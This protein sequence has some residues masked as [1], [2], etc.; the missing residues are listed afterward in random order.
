MFIAIDKGNSNVNPPINA[1]N[2][3][4]FAYD[5]ILDKLT[6]KD[7]MF[8]HIKELASYDFES[9]LNVN[10][11]GHIFEQSLSDLE[12]LKGEIE[13]VSQ[14]KQKSKRKKDGIFYTPEYI[15][16]YIVEQTVGKYLDENPQMLETITILDPACGCFFA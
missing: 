2:G 12:Q 4:L 3:G 11:L 7:E 6:I 13:G 15:T 14:D 8:T 9:D 16:R 5:E 10:I 1:Y